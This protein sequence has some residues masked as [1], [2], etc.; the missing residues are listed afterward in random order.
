MISSYGVTNRAKYEYNIL[1]KIKFGKICIYKVTR[2]P[3]LGSAC[4]SDAECSSISGYTG[5]IVCENQL[6]KLG[7]YLNTRFQSEKHI[8]IT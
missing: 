5:T 3:A 2:F 4:S 1:Y 6:C 7:K 8:S